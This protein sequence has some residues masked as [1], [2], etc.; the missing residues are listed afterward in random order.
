MIEASY[1][2]HWQE[3]LLY[4]RAGFETEACA[5]IQQWAQQQHIAIHCLP[6][7]GVVRVQVAPNAREKLTR[8]HGNTLWF[9]RQWLLASAPI[10]LPDARDRLTPL[11]THCQTQAVQAIVLETADTNE[12]KTLSRFC[13]H[14]APRLSEALTACGC[15]QADIPQ[16]PRLHLFWHDAQT[17][18]VGY[19]LP[20]SSSPWPMGIPRLKF[21][22]TAPSRS[23]LKL[24]EAFSVLLSE[25]ERVHCLKAGMR[26]VDLGACPGGWTYQL[27]QRGIHTLG[28]DNGRLHPSLL[29]SGLAQH[30]AADGFRYRPN[31]PVDWLVCDMVEQPQRVIELIGQWFSQGWCRYS[32]FN[33]KLP[34]KQRW[35]MLQ[36]CLQ[37][38]DSQLK[39]ANI[40]YQLRGKQLYHDREEVTIWLRRLDS[41]RNNKHKPVARNNISG[42][43]QRPAREPLR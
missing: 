29:A 17:V 9:A 11:L 8:L 5:E 3:G 16:L 42:K 41:K 35:P 14:F 15:Y 40:T 23:T 25:T 39:Q 19:S 36:R 18:Q 30:I 28:I 32:I 26:A 43:K 1:P 12:A 4:C 7:P 22:A 2:P 33:L 34:M 6:S 37:Q 31:Q 20:A 13:R 10:H 21:P 38:L 27:V 24:A